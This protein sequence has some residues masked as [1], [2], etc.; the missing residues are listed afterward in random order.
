M[1]EFSQEVFDTLC[2][3]LADGKSL[4]KI[5]EDHDMPSTTAVMKWLAK[6]GNDHLVAQ[7]ARARDMQADTLFD[8][9]LAI[10]DQ[11]ESKAEKSEGGTDHI[12]RAKLRIDTRK[13]MA[14]KLRPKR[15]GDKLDVDANVGLTVKLPTGSQNI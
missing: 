10:A 3:R 14:G 12:N 7:Y 6:E 4:R 1:V 9:C 11:Y 13:W 5:C 15:Y 8:D 2:E